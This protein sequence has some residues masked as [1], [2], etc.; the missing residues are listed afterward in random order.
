MVALGLQF[1]CSYENH[2]PVLGDTCENCTFRTLIE[3]FKKDSND[4]TP[5]DPTLPPKRIGVR[6]YSNG[7]K[8]HENPP[9]QKLQLCIL[10]MQSLQLH[11]RDQQ[12][13][14]AQLH[15]CVE[16]HSLTEEKHSTT[17][18]HFTKQCPST[19]KTKMD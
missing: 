2:Q 18:R 13:K 7:R 5:A 6:I 3:S 11:K 15:T 9:G 17:G 4:R 10:S 12:E 19:D 14:T 1:K 8:T 16:R